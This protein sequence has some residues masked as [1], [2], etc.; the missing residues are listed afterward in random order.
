M[1]HSE[2]K[3][4]ISIIED[5]EIYC[6]WLKIEQVNCVNQTKTHFNLY[7]KIYLLDAFNR[8]NTFLLLIVLAT[9]MPSMAITGIIANA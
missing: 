3:A 9:I 6:E 7:L 5:S 4:T 2:A 1:K 8:K